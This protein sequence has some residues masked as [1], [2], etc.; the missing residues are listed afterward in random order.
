MSDQ[1]Q[2]TSEQAEAIKHIKDLML[3]YG[4]ARSDLAQMTK[5]EKAALVQQIRD[6]MAKWNIMPWELMGHGRRTLQ[7]ETSAPPAK[8]KYRHPQTRQEW[9]GVGRQPQWLKDALIME[10]LTVEQLRV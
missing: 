2:Y 10:G 1:Q 3:T 4:I 5:A 7:V 6:L 9:N 8:V